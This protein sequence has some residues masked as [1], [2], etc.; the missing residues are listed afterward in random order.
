MSR[1]EIEKDRVET[2]EGARAHQKR[3]KK[4]KRKKNGEK[5]KRKKKNSR[6]SLVCSERR[7]RD[8]PPGLLRL[9][10]GGL[11]PR[12][13]GTQPHGLQGQDRPRR[14]GEELRARVARSGGP[15]QRNRKRKQQQQRREGL[16]RRPASDAGRGLLVVAVAPAL[17]RATGGRSFLFFRRRGALSCSS[18]CS[19]S[20]PSR[21]L[22]RAPRR[23]HPRLG[24]ALLPRSRG[25]GRRRRAVGEMAVGPRRL[26]PGRRH[27][28]RLAGAAGDPGGFPAGVRAEGDLFHSNR[29]LLGVQQRSPRPQLAFA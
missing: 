2:E 10:H 17:C 27:R 1:R 7:R 23:L 4:G 5:T 28:G 24:P 29:R 18:F 19:P 26:L 14:R 15:S 13:R 8:P 12:P 16:G 9:L 11:R 21:L 22:R 25:E 6:R 3:E 20:R